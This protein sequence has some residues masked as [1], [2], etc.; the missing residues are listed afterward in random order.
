MYD[1][2]KGFGANVR[3]MQARFLCGKSSHYVNDGKTRINLRVRVYCLRWCRASF[4]S[5]T[6]IV[7][8]SQQRNPIL[9]Y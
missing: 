7:S 2:Y 4:D 5:W 6:S 3:T 8:K 9:R 1:I